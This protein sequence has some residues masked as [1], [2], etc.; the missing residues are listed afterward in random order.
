MSLNPVPR[1]GLVINHDQWLND[2]SYRAGIR[3]AVREFGKDGLA[4]ACLKSRE[5]CIAEPLS[6]TTRRVALE[7]GLPG[8]FA[9]VN[10]RST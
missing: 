6:I 2:P 1:R 8:E 7:L 9:L 4:L 5:C 3:A 10:S